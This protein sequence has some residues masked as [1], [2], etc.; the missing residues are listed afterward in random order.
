MMRAHRPRRSSIRSENMVGDVVWFPLTD[1]KKTRNAYKYGSINEGNDA[2]AD[3]TDDATADPFWDLIRVSGDDFTRA[4]TSRPAHR[5]TKHHG[6]SLLV[7]E[8]G[9]AMFV[10][11]T[12][13]D[14]GKDESATPQFF[15]IAVASEDMKDIAK[16]I[17][18]SLRSVQ[19]T[20]DMEGVETTSSK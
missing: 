9:G 16:K 18:T 17:L 15:N 1:N 6:S 10:A 2:E 11:I 8:L 7:R 19:G 4:Y 13:D 14:S 12:S 5:L 20:A 3:S